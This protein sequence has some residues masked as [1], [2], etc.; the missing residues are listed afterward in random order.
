MFTTSSPC[1]LR[2]AIVAV[3]LSLLAPC[4]LAQWVEFSDETNIRMSG[5]SERAD[6]DV[7]EKD[8]AWGDVDMDGDID[9][10]VVRKQ[11][12]TT[13][14]Q[15]PNVLFINMGGVLTDRTSEF[16][17]ASDVAGDQGFDTP[18]NDRDV[19][20]ADVD[21]DGWL[22]IIT[23]TAISAGEP[24][25]IGYPRIY[26]N[27]GCT[28]TCSGTAEWLGFRYEDA[29]IPEMLTDSGQSGFNP[30]FCAVSAGDVTGDGYV[31][32]WF[33]DYD[34]ACGSGDFNDKLLVNQGASNP[35]FFDDVTETSFADPGFP[36]SAFGA[37]GDIK[38]MNGDD[39]NDLVKQFAGFVG[40]AFN[41]PFDLGFFHEDSNPYGGS[42]YFVSTGELN[43]DDQLDLVVADDGQDRYLL[44]QGNG[45]DDIPDFISFLYSFLNTDGGSP[46]D[47]DG[48]GGNTLVAD[49]DMA[50]WNDVLITDIDVDVGGCSRR[51][52]IYKNLGG[53]PGSDVVLQEQVQGTNCQ[54]FLGNPPECIVASIPSN[55]LEGVHDVA[56]FD[57]NGD[58]WNDMVVG[59]CSGTEVWINQP[60][61]APA[62]RVPNGDDS[63]GPQMVMD[64]DPSIEDRIV[65]TWG[66]SCAVTDTNYEI[67]HGDIG[68]YPN[69]TKLFCD[70]LGS[71]SWTFSVE[72]E[73][74][75]Y[76]L[77]VPHNETFEGS[78][79]KGTDLLRPPGV[80]TCRPQ[81]AAICQ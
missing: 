4:A 50:G 14:G 49:L 34:T 33:V 32:L 45:S 70:T 38:D 11:P 28:G 67:Y 6:G 58:T 55:Q 74:S 25:H 63:P 72:P 1:W 35:G 29:R 2:Y 41:D 71:T 75:K 24:K 46:G 80:E 18:T 31:D 17:I 23:T 54:S 76:Y 37:S 73:T 62:G 77:V 65:L 40:L 8:Y 10:V 21:N 7:Q 15:H 39:Q 48:F 30:C 16:A 79:G 69:H 3:T 60:P 52:H 19:A 57:V 36:V 66:D 51:M 64:K 5:D 47:D 68:D 61:I 44:N 43:N 26:M 53:E 78:Y 27:L 13:S 56:V 22:D 12:F 81:V 9:L 59:R 42:A 20:L